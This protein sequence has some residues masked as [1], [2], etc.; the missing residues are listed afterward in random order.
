[1][2]RGLEAGKTG[3]ALPGPLGI[4]RRA[5]GLYRHAKAEQ[6]RGWQGGGQVAR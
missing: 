5:P 2:E 4:V 1:M 6:P 3:A